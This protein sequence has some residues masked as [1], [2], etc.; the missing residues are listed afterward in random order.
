MMPFVEKFGLLVSSIV[1][2]RAGHV[3]V[4]S[5][6]LGPLDLRCRAWTGRRVKCRFRAP[7]V[8]DRHDNVEYVLALDLRCARLGPGPCSLTSP[9]TGQT[10][11]AWS[12]SCQQLKRHD[13]ANESQGG[14]VRG[15]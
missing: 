10:G 11:L 4:R 12:G 7:V 8:L 13:T 3:A 6:R 14:R 1:C 9:C 15:A 5:I 2:S